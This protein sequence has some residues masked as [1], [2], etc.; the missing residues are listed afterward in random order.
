[1]YKRYRQ[2]AFFLLLALVPM[3]AGAQFSPSSDQNRII[4]RTPRKAGYDPSIPAIQ[5]VE[6][7]NIDVEY[8]DDLGRLIQRVNWQSGPQ[9]YD[10]VQMVEYDNFGRE[11]SKYLPYAKSPANAGRY[12]RVP[13]GELYGYYSMELGPSI[14]KS[15]AP[16]AVANLESSPLGRVLQQGAPGWSWQ[17]VSTRNAV[18]TSDSTGHSTVLEYGTNLAGDVRLWTINSSNNGASAINGTTQVFYTKDRL[19][20][21]RTKDENWVVSSGRAGVAEEYTDLAG[22]TVLK[23][24][25][26]T[27]TKKLDTYYIYDDLGNLRYVIPPG[28]PGTTFSE[29]ATGDFAELVYA[30]SYDARRR[31]IR[32]KVPG[33]DW[34][35]FVYNGKDQL[36]LSQ[37]GNQ[38][39]RQ[40]WSFTRYDGLGRVTSTGLYVNIT[41]LTLEQMTA[42]VDGLE[43]PL[44]ENRGGA[45]DYP[46]PSAV[47]PVASSGSTIMVLT[48]NYYDDYAFTGASGMPVKGLAK[49]TKTQGL[50]T[51]TRIYRD[52]GTGPML[53]VHYY[54]GKGRMVQTV[55][56]NHIGGIDTETNTYGFTN[57]LLTSRRE[58]RPTSAG[59][60]TTVLT[61]NEYDHGGRLVQVRKKVNSQAEIIQSRMAYNEI[62][63][64]K[65]KSL[66]SENGG[67]NF[68]TSIAYSYNERGWQTGAVSPLFSY[69]LDYNVSGSVL[70]PNAQYNGNI[71]R[72]Q[73]KHTY[74]GSTWVNDMFTY[75]YDALNRLKS[76]VSTG[77]KEVLTYDDMGNIRTLTRDNGAV[78]AYSYNNTNKSNR[79]A[80]LSGGISGSFAYDLNGNATKDRTGMSFSYNHLDL[81]KTAEKAG[82]SVSNLYDAMGNKLR[83]MSTVGSVST[84]RNYV[85]G[86]E[87]SMN[88]TGLGSIER[89]A[90]ED[91]FL[92]NSSGT[93]S[94]Y[95]N[96][97]DHL[98]NVRVVFKKDGTPTA[99]VAV[100]MQ[101]QD[102]YPFGK[103]KNV[104]T[105]L[106]NKY[107]YNG[108][109]IQSELGGGTHTLG[110]SYV[111]EGQ[112]D[113]GARFY[114][115]EIGRWNV[116]DPLAD[117]F[118]DVSPYNYGMNNPVLMIDPTGM[119]AD[120]T[121][122][123]MGPIV[124]VWRNIKGTLVGAMTG[125]RVLEIPK[126]PPVPPPHPA[127]FVAVLVS[128]PVNVFEPKRNTDEMEW[129]RNNRSLLAKK[130]QL[131]DKLPTPELNKEKFNKKRGNQGWENKETGEIYQKSHTAHGNKNNEGTQWK[132]WPKGTSDFGSNSK[133]S[134]ERTTL[135]QNGI[136][137]G[138]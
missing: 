63:Q 123:I 14:F 26:E 73:W 7:V 10:V 44:W 132:V 93:Y 12:T 90:T 19:R 83:K 17:P 110:S 47:F 32:K 55:S 138:N 28:F 121:G 102:Y 124:D 39:K 84:E 72:Q 96:L 89:I 69:Q 16:V 20:M 91:G 42:Y 8:F 65:S 52:D 59:S 6:D 58:H 106:D 67:V 127:V 128:I 77:L 57:E 27:D 25:W 115:A 38:R 119:A 29:S 122:G 130:H 105:S 48:V 109:E 24:R 75:S 112:Y 2:I 34:Q 66:H 104:A 80:G 70:L 43:Q 92:L 111:L 15:R 94:Y 50:L 136:V 33:K 131:G 40:R 13:K 129:Y 86:I 82:T 21:K 37:D 71:A 11:S 46:S 56:Q 126:L 74:A 117:E 125:S 87:Y 135:D 62:G 36:I 98:G 118:E 53:T 134:G 101:R 120:T 45:S 18:V 97:T 76:G 103:T 1:M 81:P 99:P 78:V 4:T 114:D 49:S 41:Q 68:A 3:L 35:W 23:R 85:D 108:K 100:V 116:V 22:R 137:I 30:Y 60:L 64:L 54:D 61:T 107:L 133:R 51:G 5:K 113:Y 31:V 79:L 88:G 9:K 95:Y